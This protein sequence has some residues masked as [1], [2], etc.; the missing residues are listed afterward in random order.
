MAACVAAICFYKPATES[1][2]FL[3]GINSPVLENSMGGNPPIFF[4][5]I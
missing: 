4:E 3:F 1:I 5:K 2:I